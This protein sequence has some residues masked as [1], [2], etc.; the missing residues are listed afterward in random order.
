MESLKR[1]RS[2]LWCFVCLSAKKAHIS[3]VM[4]SNKHLPAVWSPNETN[5]DWRAMCFD[6]F[7]PQT[8]TVKWQTTS[9][10]KSPKQGLWPSLSASICTFKLARFSFDCL[11]DFSLDKS[12]TSAGPQGCSVPADKLDRL[13]FSVTTS[14]AEMC[15]LVYDNKDVA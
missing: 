11:T 13:S 8:A 15:T 12:T 4:T 5:K 6:R 9:G 1:C 10:E 14:A 7:L 3:L 2:I